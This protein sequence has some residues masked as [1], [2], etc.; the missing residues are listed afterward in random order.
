MAIL[1]FCSSSNFELINTQHSKKSNSFVALV[2]PV[3][4]VV[5]DSSDQVA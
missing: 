3:Y 4:H 1:L 2:F 5:N